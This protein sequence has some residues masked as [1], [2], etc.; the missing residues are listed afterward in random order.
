MRQS[1]CCFSAGFSQPLYME[2]KKKKKKIYFVKNTI[3]NPNQD[4]TTTTKNKTKPHNLKFKRF[5]SYQ[6]RVQ[7]Q[8]VKLG[9]IKHRSW[10]TDRAADM[11]K[12]D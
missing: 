2:L 10:S 12:I 4:K 11:L 9:R 5:L 3:P 7:L 1:L 6:S 8:K